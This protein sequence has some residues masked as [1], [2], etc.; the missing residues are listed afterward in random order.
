MKEC[1]D[2]DG[3]GSNARSTTDPQGW[4]PHTTGLPVPRQGVDRV[5]RAASRGEAD[6][7]IFQFGPRLG[8]KTKPFQCYLVLRVPWMYKVLD[9]NLSHDSHWL[10][11]MFA[12][13][14]SSG[15]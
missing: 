13:C 12:S 10:H 6:V 14:L 8:E 3:L 9:C 4:Q 2:D 1:G 15:C 11:A 5:T 7:E